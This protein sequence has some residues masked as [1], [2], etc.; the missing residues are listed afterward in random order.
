VAAM[1]VP[2][3]II[4]GSGLREARIAQ[5][6]DPLSPY[7]IGGVIL[8]LDLSGNVPE[9]LELRKKS[10]MLFPDL[11]WTPLEMARMLREAGRGDEAVAELIRG[12]RSTGATPLATA[13]E[14]EY[15]AHGADRAIRLYLRDAHLTRVYSRWM[16]ARFHALVGDRQAA[17]D[18]LERSYANGEAGVVFANAAR[19]FAPLRE[20]PRFR[21]LIAK[22]NLD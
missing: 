19:E 4:G 1:N 6:I 22:M 11:N 9:A 14:K 16:S 3:G 20:E 12:L 13:V 5:K 17:L 7:A 2:I 18:D 10:A 8:V 21:A 15:R